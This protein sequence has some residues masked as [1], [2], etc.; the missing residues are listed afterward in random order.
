MT[1]DIYLELDTIHMVEGILD[2]VNNP[3]AAEH[4]GVYGIKF[5]PLSVYLLSWL[6]AW[7]PARAFVV[8]TNLLTLGAALITLGDIYIA[9]CREFPPRRLVFSLAIVALTPVY[10]YYAITFHPYVWALGLFS[11]ALALTSSK[12]PILRIGVP[13]LMVAVASL[14]RKDAILFVP[15]LMERFVRSGKRGHIILWISMFAPVTLLAYHLLSG[16]GFVIAFWTTYRLARLPN[17]LLRGLGPLLLLSMVIVTVRFYREFSRP[18]FRL[19]LSWA[20]P[21]LL[22]Y[23][24]NPTPP[25]HL[26]LV[27]Y[28]VG[29]FVGLAIPLERW[30][31]RRVHRLELVLTLALIVLLCQSVMVGFQIDRRARARRAQFNRYASA[32]Q[33]SGPRDNLLLVYWQ[34]GDPLFWFW[35]ASNQGQAYTF[36]RLRYMDP[37]TER[38]IGDI[39]RFDLSG[40]KVYTVPGSLL[41]R[42]TGVGDIVRAAQDRVS[43]SMS[44][45]VPL[46]AHE[47][48]AIDNFSDH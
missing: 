12:S 23:G 17:T 36:S 3:D 44:E 39:F 41:Q 38:Y 40:R 27:A 9:Y 2:R 13:V 18:Y 45:F 46:Y 26:L 47:A 21:S 15:I 48:A 28:A 25:R 1:A 6:A 4:M 35:I 10:G 19:V 11:I 34:A 42:H 16:N 43:E 5:A 29:L 20:L 24:A 37:Q 7:L 32:I 30:S 8:V 31:V 22:F 14:I 33:E